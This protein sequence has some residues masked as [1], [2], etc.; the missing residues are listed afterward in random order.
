M[1]LIYSELSYLIINRG[2]LTARSIHFIGIQFFWRKQVYSEC[3]LFIHARVWHSSSAN[4]Q[5]V[6]ILGFRGHK[7][8]LQS[9]FLSCKNSAVPYVNE[10][11]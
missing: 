5:I 4:V 1:I 9:Q 10:F 11:T 3:Y 8:L 6:N 2:I 7:F